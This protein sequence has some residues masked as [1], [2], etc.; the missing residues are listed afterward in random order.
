MSSM[1]TERLLAQAKEDRLKKLPQYAQKLISELAYQ[2]SLEAKSAEG[3]RAR[4]EREVFEARAIA[5]QGPENSDTFL[6]LP[7]SLSSYEDEAQKPLGTG[8]AVEFRD[9]ELTSG[10]GTFVR[11]EG[12]KI[13]VS[14][15][16]RLAVIPEDAHTLWIEER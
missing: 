12:D 1:R 5:A 13:K 15:M 9:P 10:E 4:A 7:R 11:R 14:S 6:E 2:L 16:S 3:A 8:V